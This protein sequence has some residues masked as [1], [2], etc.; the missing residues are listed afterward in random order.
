M[1][2]F[3][4]LYFADFWCHYHRRWHGYVTRLPPARLRHMP[5]YN[6]AFEPCR[7]CWRADCAVFQLLICWCAIKIRHWEAMPQKKDTLSVTGGCRWRPLRACRGASLVSPPLILRCRC[8]Q[9][10]TLRVC[11]DSQPGDTPPPMPFSPFYL[12]SIMASQL[13]LRL[14][15]LISPRW[16][17]RFVNRRCQ[18]HSVS[19]ARSS[20]RHIIFASHG[21][22]CSMVERSPPTWRHHY[23]TYDTGR[24]YCIYYYNIITRWRDYCHT[25]QH[26]AMPKEPGALIYHYYYTYHY[27]DMMIFTLRPLLRR[28]HR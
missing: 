1:P 15:Q 21:K 13:T 27:G 26:W 4:L 9:R 11:I 14:K 22:K 2:G 24:D 17:R 10:Y 12:F 23:A 6:A 3:T 19:W 16:R 28:C 7:R 5:I 8:S 25:F 20:L 18:R